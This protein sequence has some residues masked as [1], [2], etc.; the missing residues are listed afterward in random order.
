[1]FPVVSSLW[2][3]RNLNVL[4]FIGFKRLYLKR[5][6]HL[7]FVRF[8]VMLNSTPNFQVTNP[9]LARY[10]ALVELVLDAPLHFRVAVV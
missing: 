3:F 9:N 8:K 6:T 10:G 2:D 4:V 5:F 7:G 1:M